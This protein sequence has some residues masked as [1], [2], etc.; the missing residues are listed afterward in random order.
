MS[1]YAWSS[2]S[3]PQSYILKCL[4]DSSA[5]SAAELVSAPGVIRLRASVNT[6]SGSLYY[7]KSIPKTTG[8]LKWKIQFILLCG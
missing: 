4:F 3:Y 1:C 2:A 8:E 7:F 6:T 5:M